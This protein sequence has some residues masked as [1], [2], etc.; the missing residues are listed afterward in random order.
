M[1]HLL[2]NPKPSLPYIS[3]LLQ[4]LDTHILTD[5]LITLLNQLKM[6]NTIAFIRKNP[7]LN[8]VSDDGGGKGGE[9][10]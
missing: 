5:P 4:Y 2:I 3:T 9:G 8:F 7:S 10:N 6:F 1:S